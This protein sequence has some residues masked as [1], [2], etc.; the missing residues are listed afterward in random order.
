MPAAIDTRVSR[1]ESS[2]TEGLKEIKDLIV[3]EI[4]DLKNDQLKDIKGT[5]DR[6]EKDL[7]N[8]H[9]RL[10]DDQRRLWDRVQAIELRENQ[11]IG[12]G[13]LRGSIWHIGSMMLGA[14]ITAI[15]TWL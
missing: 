1:L 4:Q 12:A 7:K 5:I 8:D 14:T 6:V 10:A 9:A 3:R 11:N 13:K 15:G 2:L